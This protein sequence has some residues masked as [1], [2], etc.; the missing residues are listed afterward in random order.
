MTIP[1][2][3]ARPASAGRAAYLSRADMVIVVGRHCRWHGQTSSTK[4]P[5]DCS[6]AWTSGSALACF[7]FC[8]SSILTGKPRASQK[9]RSFDASK[10][11]VRF[12]AISME[13]FTSF[14]RFRDGTVRA[15][16]TFVQP[17]LWKRNEGKFEKFKTT[18][19][20]KILSRLAWT[21]RGQVDEQP[22]VDR[23]RNGSFSCSSTISLLFSPIS[24]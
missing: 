13:W 16:Y 9:S 10:T 21:V 5:R 2:F 7:G 14:S 1:S 19:S 12:N 18:Y 24:R 17:K 4:T 11:T 23:C 15:I 8:S 6:L 22:L 20:G 3:F